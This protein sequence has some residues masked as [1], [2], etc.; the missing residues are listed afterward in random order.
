MTHRLVFAESSRQ[1][2]RT[3]IK[4]KLQHVDVLQTNHI[5]VYI[6][7]RQYRT[8][9]TTASRSPVLT[10]GGIC[11][12]PTVNYLQCLVTGSTLTAIGP[13]QLPASQSGTLSRILSRSRPSAETV[14]GVCLKR[15][16]SLDT[17]AFSVLEVPDD[18]CAL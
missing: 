14:S 9:R 2:A 15:I 8:C 6:Y 5:C 1:P 12:P 16:C 10:L 13:F 17:S 4:Y 7:S 3:I 11:V 18:N